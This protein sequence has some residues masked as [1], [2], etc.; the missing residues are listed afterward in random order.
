VVADSAAGQE[1]GEQGRAS[2]L[3]AIT[4]EE[5]ETGVESLLGAE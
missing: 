4:E 2:T 1:V 5:L 3:G